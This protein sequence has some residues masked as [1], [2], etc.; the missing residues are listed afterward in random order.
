MAYHETFLPTEHNIYFRI[1]EMSGEDHLVQ[2]PLQATPVRLTR[3]P[4]CHHDG[5]SEHRLFR[6]AAWTN[7]L[8]RTQLAMKNLNHRATSPVALRSTLYDPGTRS[9]G[10]SKDF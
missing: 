10:Q 8:D 9:V 4:S 6:L 3:H 5:Y 1:D 2:R 7:R